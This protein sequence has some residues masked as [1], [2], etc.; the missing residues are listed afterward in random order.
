MV[1]FVP[2]H[3]IRARAVFVFVGHCQSA[4]YAVLRLQGIA[5]IRR[6]RD[7]P[8]GPPG[9]SPRPDTNSLSQS[10][11]RKNK[12]RGPWHARIGVAISRPCDAALGTPEPFDKAIVDNTEVERLDVPAALTA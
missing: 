8:W 3:A 12:P 10:H 7:L 1:L 5:L 9:P 6:V 4:E 11:L 2:I